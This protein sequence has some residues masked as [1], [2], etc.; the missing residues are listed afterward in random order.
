MYLPGTRVCIWKGGARG[1]KFDRKAWSVSMGPM[2]YFRVGEVE[3][4][5][6]REC[7]DREDLGPIVQ[8]EFEDI[9]LGPVYV[10]GRRREVEG[11][12][13]ISGAGN[14]FGAL[15]LEGRPLPR[16]ATSQRETQLLRHLGTQR[17]VWRRWH[18][19]LSTSELNH[20]ECGHSMI[21]VSSCLILIFI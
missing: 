3:E 1:S 17:L 10:V 6:R 13:H 20:A 7:E 21:S 15:S 14:T 4:W 19:S 5:L 11:G 18:G 2:Y 8:C 9:Y 12:G 16:A